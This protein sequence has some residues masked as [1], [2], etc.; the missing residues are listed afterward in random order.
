MP[1]LLSR[2]NL[3]WKK[4]TNTPIIVRVDHIDAIEQAWKRERPDLDVAPL[5]LLGRLFRAAALADERLG[6]G[7]A[8]RGL[9]A[10]WFDLL[11][12]LRRAGNP[13]ELNPSEL[14]S[15]TMLSSGGMTKRLDRL[16]EA[17]LVERRPDPGDRRGT[18]VRLTPRGRKAID[19][20]LP[21]HLENEERLLSR[22]SA[23]ERGRLDALLRKLLV[24]LEGDHPG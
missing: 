6:E 4:L 1:R 11:A 22:L 21:V 15:A 3:L 17:G 13:Y 23:A 10:G 5:A 20:A 24:D 12:A 18:L 9:R 8:A 14:M 7:L 2:K 19:N 16:A